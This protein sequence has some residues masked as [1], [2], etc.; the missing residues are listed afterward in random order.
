MI[1]PASTPPALRLRGCC[2]RWR[3]GRS[4]VLKTFPAIYRPALR[5]LEG[6]RSFLRALRADRLG[7]HSLCCSAGRCATRRAVC[8]ACFTPLGLVFET[9]V[10]EKHLLARCEYELGRTFGAFQD[11]I[12]VFHT[13]L[14]NDLPG[15]RQ[16]N[17][18]RRTKWKTPCESA[19]P[20]SP[21]TNCLSGP[22]QIGQ[23]VLLTPLLFAETLT[24][25]GFFR[26][27]PF[28][29]FHVVAVLFDLLDNVLRLDLPFKTPERIL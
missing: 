4:P 27:P 9:L 28:T 20:T 15:V 2:G 5:R 16:R 6:N 7:L 23:L 21:S 19:F 3:A 13:L 10:G 29:W 12:V 22:R 24:R 25:E 14:R 1:W 8:L 17:I 18:P 11:S 26:T